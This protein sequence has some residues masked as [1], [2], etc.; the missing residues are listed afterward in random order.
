MSKTKQQIAEE[1]ILGE[2]NAREQKALAEEIPG[3]AARIEVIRGGSTKA[4]DWVQRSEGG[5][6]EKK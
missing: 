2:Q 1:K 6:K 3:E 5:G 4:A